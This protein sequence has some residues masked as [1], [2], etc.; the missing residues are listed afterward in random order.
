MTQSDASMVLTGLEL[1]EFED[2]PADV[3]AE[4]EGEIE[5][6]D[7]RTYC[8][9]NRVS[10]GEMIA[11]DGAHCDTEWVN[12]LHSSAKLLIDWKCLSRSSISRAFSSSQLRKERGTATAAPA[13][14][15]AAGAKAPP[16]AATR[17]KNSSIR[18]NG[19]LM[20]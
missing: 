3:D 17:K 11:C 10:F 4:L 20:P 1:D 6:E 8:Y 14:L 13:T 5:G 9:C 12:R 18:T 7:T 16:P 15:T 2:D 19:L